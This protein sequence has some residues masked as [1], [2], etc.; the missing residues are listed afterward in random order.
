VGHTVHS[1]GEAQTRQIASVLAQR[2]GPG[3]I[4]LLTGPL[5]AGKTTFVRGFL[6]G[7]GYS[8]PVRS[9]TFNLVQTFETTPR[10]MHADLYRVSSAVGLDL[11][12]YFQEYVCMIEWA[13]RLGFYL[14]PD[15]CWR[16]H[17]DFTEESRS[18]TI[19]SPT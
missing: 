3:D 16:V 12:S 17:L 14:D 15:S 8:E 4:L 9:P 6:E 1:A 7:L 13:D 10:V 2:L 5:G 19:E 18:I 11:E